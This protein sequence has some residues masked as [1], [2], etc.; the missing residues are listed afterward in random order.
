MSSTYAD[1]KKR[2]QEERQLKATAK[3]GLIALQIFV[4]EAARP[5]V[6]QMKDVKP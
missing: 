1:I 6:S 4:L 2:R 3:L 5:E